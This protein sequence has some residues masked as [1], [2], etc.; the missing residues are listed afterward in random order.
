MRPEG[1]QGLLCKEQQGRY[2]RQMEQQLQI[3]EA[4]KGMEWPRHGREA[5]G[6]TACGEYE[7][8]GRILS[9]RGP[10]AAFT[11]LKVSSLLHSGLHLPQGLILAKPSLSPLLEGKGREFFCVYQD[12]WQRHGV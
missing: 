1:Q 2:S 5:S 4:G 12:T 10:L 6:A 11:F 3:P 7:R 9:P 8:S